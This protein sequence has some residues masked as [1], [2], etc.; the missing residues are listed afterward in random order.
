MESA[1][2]TLSYEAFNILGAERDANNQILRF[3]ANDNDNEIANILPTGESARSFLRDEFSRKSTASNS[4]EPQQFSRIS[5]KVPEADL[6]TSEQLGWLAEAMPSAKIPKNSTTGIP[7]AYTYFGQFLAHDLSKTEKWD[8]PTGPLNL[9]SHAMDFDT[10][11][12]NIDA[13]LEAEQETYTKH[14][15][16][17]GHTDQGYLWDL[18]R[19]ASGQPCIADAR[20]DQN[21]MLAQLVVQI[22]KFHHRVYDLCGQPDKANHIK[23]TTRH[24]QSIALQ[25]YAERLVQPE[26]ITDVLENG[27][28]CI[29]P[30]WVAGDTFQVP[31]EFSAAVFRFG[32]SMVRNR[33]NINILHKK[34]SLKEI[35]HNT[36]LGKGIF[37]CL[38]N[39]WFV[40]YPNLVCSQFADPID[41]TLASGLTA[42]A[43]NLVDE[44]PGDIRADTYHLAKLTLLRGRSVGLPS[45]QTLIADI[46]AKIKLRPTRYGGG[47]ISIQTA[48]SGEIINGLN[49]KLRC[50][51][52]DVDS[53]GVVLKDQTPLWFYTLREAELF[54]GKC[55]RLGML[56]SR[57]VYET[58][59]A[60]VAASETSILDEHGQISFRPDSRLQPKNKDR[61]TLE[62]LIHVNHP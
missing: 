20:N 27:R 22:T 11:F 52:T 54:G 16:T 37:E 34:S 42:L 31:I 38:S 25:D 39:E 61:F 12:G 4:T 18:P 44:P 33:Y 21:L 23:I 46:N 49:D 10:L 26:I 56:A 9:Q 2:R 41:H 32:H 13:N 14:G 3:D 29:A 8:Q 35:F 55:G 17:I 47:N 43:P 1:D 58:L 5:C 62:D 30:G 19:T 59:H 57:I 36:F 40:T 6:P 51:L 53:T 7:A 28:A 48:T 15:L 45:A 50:I 24:L 60:A